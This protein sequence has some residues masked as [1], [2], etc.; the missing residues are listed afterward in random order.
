MQDGKIN[1]AP[2]ALGDTPYEYIE[3]PDSYPLTLISPASGKTISSSM[4]EYN[5]P[6]LIVT[7]NPLD[8]ADRGLSD[9]TIVRVFNE[10]GEVHCKLKVKSAIRTGV[11]SMPKGAWRKASRNQQTATA[12][13]PD[14]LGTAGGACFNDA[15]VE[16]ARLN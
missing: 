4:G 14:T 15:R 11:V 10:F 1:L 9:G 6:E 2:T 8:A 12:L 5:L 7:M 13:A 16:V 3:L